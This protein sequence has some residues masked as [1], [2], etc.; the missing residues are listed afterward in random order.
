M[1]WT[2][3]EIQTTPLENPKRPEAVLSGGLTWPDAGFAQ[4]GKFPLDA[5]FRRV[6]IPKEEL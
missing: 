1:A 5:L 2:R 4:N 3:F 6:I